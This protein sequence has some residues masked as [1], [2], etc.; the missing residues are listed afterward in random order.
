MK[1]LKWNEL[2]GDGGTQVCDEAKLTQLKNEFKQLSTDAGDS[3]NDRRQVGDDIRFNRWV[4]QSPDGKKHKIA[5]NGRAAFPFEGASDKRE[6]TADNITNE[7][8]IIM[9]GALLRFNLGF[10]GVPGPRGQAND[11]LADGLGVLW[12]WVKRNQLGMEWLTEWTKFMQWRQGDS[13]AVAFMQI[14]WHQ[15]SCVKPITVTADEVTTKAL[16]LATTQEYEVTPEDQQDLADMVANPD[17]EEEL[18][19]VLLAVWPDLREDTAKK[20]AGALTSDGTAT[21]PYP[22]ISENRLKLK[23]RRLFDD[24]YVPENTPTD[25]K[26]GRIIYVREWYSQPE[27]REREAKGDFKPG[28][29]D[30]VLKHEGE[31]GWI[32]YSRYN[33]DGEWN[34]TP[35]ERKWNKE[36]QR[37]LYEILTAIYRGSNSHGIPGIYSVDFHAYVEEAG[38]DQVLLDNPLN[39]AYPF[40]CSSREI[41]THNLWDSRG[42]SEL[43][44]TEQNALKLL[45]DSFMDNVQ[46]STVPPIEVPASRPKVAL[47]WGPLKEIRVNRQGEIKPFQPFPYPAGNEKMIGI[48]NAGLNRYFGRFADTNPPDLV[49]LYNQSLVDFMLVPVIEVIWMGLKMCLHFMPVEQL[50]QILGPELAPIAN[51]QRAADTEFRVEASFDAGMLSIEY[52]EKVGGIIANLILPMDK[53]QSVQRTEIVKWLMTGLSSQMATKLVRPKEDADMSEVEDEQYNFTQ[54]AAGIEPPM[55]TEGQNW[56]LRRQTLLNIGVKNPQAFQSLTPASKEILAARL[57]HFDGMIEQEQNAQIGRT[58]AA[59]ALA[60]PAGP[61]SLEP[62]AA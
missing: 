7:Q 44:A 37:G 12:E 25:L 36:R 58:M 50:Q 9:M 32:H 47:V 18:A 59:P 1:E 27:L 56:E 17:R 5:L 35:I 22:Y 57:K 49:R 46:L 51:Q 6:R 62:A 52:I 42:N 40:V 11:Q 41:L 43:S 29:V 24:I 30:E 53:D 34:D 48:I 33:N 15:E 2:R 10:L 38:T 21:F 54:I 55:A 61:A 4:G 28:F 20:A 60:G 26:R 16:Q 23:A 19:E 31:S 14:S 39:G 3:A 13:P 45:H 8:V